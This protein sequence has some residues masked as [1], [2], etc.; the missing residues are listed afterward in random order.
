METTLFRSFIVNNIY[1]RDRIRSCDELKQEIVGAISEIRRR[2]MQF[3]QVFKKIEGAE[4][5]TPP[6]I[7]ATIGARP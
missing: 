3:A 1:L 5:G 2:M 6:T 7:S 4:S